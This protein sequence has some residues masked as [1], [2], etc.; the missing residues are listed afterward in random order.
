MQSLGRSFIILCA[1]VV[2]LS[3]APTSEL[4]ADDGEWSCS[5]PLTARHLV[6]PGV[7]ASGPVDLWFLHVVGCPEDYGSVSLFD[8][9]SLPEQLLFS[10]LLYPGDQYDLVLTRGLHFEH[11]LNVYFEGCIRGVTVGVDVQGQEADP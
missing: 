10:V 11:A 9:P 2:L 6:E 5:R 4:S 3:L 7:V 8:H 1:C